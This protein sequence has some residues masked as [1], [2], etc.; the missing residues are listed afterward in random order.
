MWTLSTI[1]SAKDALTN[2]HLTAL[3][4]ETKAYGATIMVGPNVYDLLYPICKTSY[5]EV[6]LAL[7]RLRK[8]GS[9]YFDEIDLKGQRELRISVPGAQ[10]Y[11][12][13]VIQ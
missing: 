12:F 6:D 2:W 3:L 4:P 9:F 10:F 11:V 1:E 8:K 13:E 7:T 5:K